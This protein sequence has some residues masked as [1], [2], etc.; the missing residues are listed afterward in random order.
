MFAGS[1]KELCV[2]WGS[3][4]QAERDNIPSERAGDVVACF[5]D[6]R[7]E[8]KA[9]CDLHRAFLDNSWPGGTGFRVWKGD[10]AP[11]LPLGEQSTGLLR[12]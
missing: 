4:D 9:V 12:L 2:P 1:T 7:M 11:P 10:D 6:K 3:I 5:S 8:E